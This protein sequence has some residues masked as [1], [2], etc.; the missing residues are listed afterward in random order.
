[1]YE[2]SVRIAANLTNLEKLVDVIHLFVTTHNLKLFCQK[3]DVNKSQ[4]LFI[5]FVIFAFYFNSH[6]QTIP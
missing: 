5:F 3:H 6:S 2:N 4:I 1:M